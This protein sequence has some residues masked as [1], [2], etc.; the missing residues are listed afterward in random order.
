MAATRHPG[1][2][3]QHDGLFYRTDE[4]YLLGVGGFI[5]EGLDVGDPVYVAVPPDRIT[6]LR[7]GLADAADVHF[8]DVTHVGRNP[9]CLMP[10]IQD[11]LDEHPTA[12]TRFVGEPIWPGR[13]RPEIEEAT[14]HEA[15]KNV[16]F[17]SADAAILCPYRA[18]QLPVSVLEDAERTHPTLLTTAGA[19]PSSR[20][21]DAVA[22]CAADNWPLSSPPPHGVTRL[23]TPDMR[24]IRQFVGAQALRWGL[25]RNRAA[26]LVLAVVELCTNTLRH[27]D[28]VPEL[29]LWR[30]GDEVVAEIRDSGTITDPL[31]GRRRAGPLDE[32]GRG[33][34]LVN[35]LCDLVQIRSAEQSGTTVR[36]HV[37]VA[38]VGADMVSATG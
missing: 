13:S 31:A 21:A 1:S 9:S 11:F 36:I 24:G 28:D 19:H 32:S 30:E 2:C 17:A 35:Q 20:Y 26:D 25:P 7:A 18:D 37:G 14:T 4:E 29:L 10:M 5:Q 23:S 22:F 38:T 33:L 27:A 8:F 6:L 34:M 16:A 3:L 12:H 15:L